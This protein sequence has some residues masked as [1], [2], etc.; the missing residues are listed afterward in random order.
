M[1]VRQIQWRF[2]DRFDLQM[3]VHSVRDVARGPVARL[4]AS[5]ARQTHEWTAAKS[6][7]LRDFDAGGITAAFLDPDNGG[8]LRVRRIW[9]SR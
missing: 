7:L 3:L 1:R 4:V 2:A 9:P 8:Y 6:A 5:G